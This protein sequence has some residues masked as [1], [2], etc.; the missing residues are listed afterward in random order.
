VFDRVALVHY[1][2]IGLKGRNRSPFEHRLAANLRSAVEG[3]TDKPPYRVA[4]RL[5]VPITDRDRAEDLI[6]AVA[7]T[8]GVTTV[9]PAVVTARELD[10]ISRA[11]EFAIADFVRAPERSTGK[12]RGPRPPRTFAVKARRSST[13]FPTS[14][15][16]VNIALGDHLRTATG[17]SVDLDDPEV[18]VHVEIVQG[19]AYVYAR[20]IPGPGGLPSGTAGRVVSL[21]SAGIDSPVATWRMIKRGAV[22]IG[23]HFSGRPQTDE[24]SVLH[25]NELGGVLERSRGLARI[26]VVSFGNVQRTISLAAPPDLRVLLYRRMMVRVAEEV[27]HRERA[28]ALVTGESLGQVASQ[29]LEN[30]A[31]VDD[32]ATMPVLRPL[33]GM[34]KNEIMADARRIGTF[35]ISTQAHDDCCTLFMPRMPATHA[36]VEQ[37]V[38]GEA[39]LDVPG[40]VAEALASI[41]HRD[42]ICPAYGKRSAGK[43]DAPV[44][45]EA[46]G[47]GADES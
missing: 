3:L 20:R 45:D 33:I 6:A 12:A 32:V 22:V 28:R 46:P 15:R 13:D 42:F 31:A 26:H 23:V 34:D 11:A 30:V 18:T 27:A 39:D 35:D 36:S 10:Q 4:S 21:L 43:G 24:R 37:V 29:T 16:E 2:E 14:S 19:F 25:V 17:M 9:S 41:E 1:H 38:A 8:P 47:A 5:L 44:A 7:A 40:L